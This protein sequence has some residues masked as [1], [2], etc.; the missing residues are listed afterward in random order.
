MGNSPIQNPKGMEIKN[1]HNKSTQS[2][3]ESHTV[4]VREGEREG[5]KMEGRMEGGRQAGRQQDKD[6]GQVTSMVQQMKLPLPT[7]AFQSQASAPLPIQL[8]TNIP[9]KAMDRTLPST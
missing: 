8:P 9:R 7:L 4:T 3:A 6:I 5:G 2:L 1:I